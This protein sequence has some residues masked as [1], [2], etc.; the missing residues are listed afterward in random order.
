MS[1]YSLALPRQSSGDGGAGAEC[2]EDE[3]K[4]KETAGSADRCCLVFQTSILAL[5]SPTYDAS[6]ANVLTRIRPSPSGWDDYPCC[7]TALGS[8]I[9]IGWTCGKMMSACMRLRYTPFMV[10]LCWSS[11]SCCAMKEKRRQA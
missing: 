10:D 2:Q 7:K 9:G 11:P 1:R 4:K 3:E 8:I 5:P 6:P